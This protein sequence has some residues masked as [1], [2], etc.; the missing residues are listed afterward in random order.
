M[1]LKI[2][3]LLLSRDITCVQEAD[4]FECI[5]Q[6]IIKTIA[7][8]LQNGSL[9]YDTFERIIQFR[10]NSIWHKK[11]QAEYDFVTSIIAL[12]K[13]LEQLVYVLNLFLII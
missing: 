9:D 11:H 3:G 7:V 12:F 4:V 13:L 5:D 6:H 8:S 1:E 2:E 10:R